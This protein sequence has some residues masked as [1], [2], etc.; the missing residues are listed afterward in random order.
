MTTPHLTVTAAAIGWIPVRLGREFRTNTKRLREHRNLG[1]RM[2]VGDAEGWGEAYTME[3]EAGMEALGGVRFEGW[4]AEAPE[5]LDVIPDL[6]ARSAADLAL[7]DARCRAL[8]VPLHRLL[9]LPEPRTVTSVSL[10]LASADEVL[11]EARAWLD[12]G[13]TRIKL[14][15]GA[16][17]DPGLPARLREVVGDGVGIRVDGNQ[18]WDAKSYREVLPHLEAARVEF[19]EQPF[20]VGMS[21]LCAEVHTAAV[22]IFL[23]EEITGPDDV[24]RV[25][26]HGGVDGVNVKL[27]KCGG[28]HRSL[29][30]IR[31]ARAHGL[32]VMIGCYFE[33]SLATAAAV[34]LTSLADFVDL[35]APL[36]L[37]EDPF[38]G[39]RYEE[40]GP[41]VGGGP[42]IGVEPKREI[43]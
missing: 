9:Q 6:P 30:T 33:S 13:Y 20:P 35:D 39:L 31:V 27:A 14:K 1:V 12:A 3:P 11:A 28:I 16:G 34:H 2:R 8:G 37:E 21:E 18:A 40:G 7:H 38:A 23:D 4:R 22:P 24:A 29:E 17:T 36:F 41:R 42:G 26:G 32:G 15:M 10:S 43:F 25:A 5:D 19:C